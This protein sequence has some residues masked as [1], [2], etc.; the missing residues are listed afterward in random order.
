MKNDGGYGE[1]TRK[2]QDVWQL[3]PQSRPLSPPGSCFTLENRQNMIN[4]ADFVCTFR[5]IMK[6]GEISWFQALLKR[7][8]GG[9]LFDT[10][11]ILP[12]SKCWTGT[13]TKR[14]KGLPIQTT[15]TVA[16]VSSVIGLS[17]MSIVSLVPFPPKEPLPSQ[18]TI[19]LS[20]SASILERKQ[21]ETCSFCI[22]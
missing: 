18:Y 7:A 1:V 2:L 22:D 21:E 8:D 19:Q 16:N 13:H 12:Q 5:Q 10:P 4:D 11:I 20:S 17:E 6:S 3:S 9:R 14:R 15:E